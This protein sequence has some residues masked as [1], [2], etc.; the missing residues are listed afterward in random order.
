MSDHK[1]YNKIAGIYKLYCN[2]NGKIYIGKSV[3][4]GKRLN[5][6]KNCKRNGKVGRYFQN[7]ILKYGWESF[8]IEILE[9]FENFDKHTHNDDLL[10]RETYYIEL[11]ES[12]DRSKGYN[13]CKSSTDMTGIVVS[14]ETREK[15]RQNMLGRKLSPE[16][17]EKMRQSRLGKVCSDETKEKIRQKRLGQKHTKESN[18][19]LRQSKL[20]TIL[21]DET[22]EK[23]S[24]SQLGITH[25]D[26]TKE[27]I[28]QKLLGRTVSKDTRE[29]IRQNKLGRKLSPE[30]REK[31]RQSR[32][33]YLRSK[34]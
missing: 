11:F 14:V 1:N 22:K 3:N 15:M 16:T 17:R 10:K 34:D 2:N 8:T 28:R 26:E 32:L 13:I 19:K 29:K 4:I 7:A 12:T 20:G 31:M 5:D 27:K 30:T 25:S 33:E 21:S 6:H 18:E 9:V 23:M 24:K